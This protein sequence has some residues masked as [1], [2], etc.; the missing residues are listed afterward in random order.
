MGKPLQQIGVAQS[1]R[2]ISIL[3]GTLLTSGAAGA[4]RAV[5]NFELQHLQRV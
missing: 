4:Q 3:Q 1:C 2:G 5:L